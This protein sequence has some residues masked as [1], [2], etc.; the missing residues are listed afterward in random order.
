VL[1]A[2]VSQHWE[3]RH[4]DFLLDQ[5]VPL[6]HEL[7]IAITVPCSPSHNRAMRRLTIALLLIC[8]GL[9]AV[10]QGQV[11]FMNRTGWGPGLIYE[12]L[13]NWNG[14]PLDARYSVQ[15]YFSTLVAKPSDFDSSLVPAGPVLTFRSGPGSGSFPT[16]TIDLPG[17]TVNQRV[18]LQAR[19]WETAG[20][21]S[22][23]AAHASFSAYYG[24]STVFRSGPLGG[25]LPG[26]EFVSPPQTIGN[27]GGPDFNLTFITMAPETTV[28]SL[29]ALGCVALLLYRRGPS[30][31]HTA[32]PVGGLEHVPSQ[33]RMENDNESVRI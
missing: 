20:G 33:N 23:E 3:Q 4:A 6:N 8:S 19:M 31:A 17:T 18:W 24:A 32:E 16:T 13:V 28:V 9:G 12:P 2:N 5:R 27:P 1:P 7:G 15:L 22:F 30:A 25:V 21:A 29:G 11:T 26:G 10:G 14:D